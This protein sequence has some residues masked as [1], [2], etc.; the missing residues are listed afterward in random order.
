MTSK[1]KIGIKNNR[2]INWKSS[3]NWIL[4]EIDCYS[5]LDL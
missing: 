2:I 1:I 4:P 5:V 3:K